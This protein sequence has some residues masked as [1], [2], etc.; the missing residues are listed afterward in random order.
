MLWNYTLG[1]LVLWWPISS[2]ASSSIIGTFVFDWYNLH[3][4]NIRVQAVNYDDE[5]G[6]DLNIFE[7]PRIDW[8]GVLWH[9]WRSKDIS[10]K[11][12]LSSDTADWLNALIDELKMKT[13][14]TEWRL[15][16]E[17]NGVVR[18]VK[19]SIVNLKFNREYYH[20]TF[21]PN[22]EITFR[23]IDPHWQKKTNTSFSFEKTDDSQE[24]IVNNGTRATNPV[25][26]VIFKTWCSGVSQLKI[27]ID[28]YAIIVSSAFVPWDLLTI[29][30]ENKI[31]QKNGTS[32]DYSW[33]FPTL[34]V[35]SNPVF[36]DYTFTTLF[37]DVFCIFN[38]RY[39]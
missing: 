18:R 26:Y 8:W 5:W 37:V 15:E 22:V 28:W 23:T 34:N 20:L 14:T 31:V 32:I 12:S 38:E 4:N 24:D 10:F 11:L 16:V 1:W 13:Q 29:D 7:A 36:F 17:V 21:L 39:L 3:S 19:A 33:V 27:T 6:I 2:F 35:G 25:F 30:C 9:Y